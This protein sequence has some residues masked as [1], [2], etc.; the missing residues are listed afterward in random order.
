LESL[1]SQAIIAELNKTTSQQ[2][3]DSKKQ[4]YL[5]KANEIE[6]GLQ[7][8][9]GYSSSMF[10]ICII[11]ADEGMKVHV[12]SK[13]QECKRELEQL[14]SQLG[15]EKYQHIEELRLLK[16]EQKKIEARMAENKRKA[17]REKDP[18]KKAAL[19]LLIEED[20]KKLE[21]NL[22]K[23][24]AIPTSKI[25]F[26]PGKHV[27]RIMEGIRRALAE[28]GRPGGIGGGSGSSGNRRNPN[29]PS[30]PFGGGN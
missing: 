19:L 18:S 14:K 3:Y 27:E 26:D 11:W 30:D 28:K 17:E 12:E 9:T 1:D 20:G 8:R 25:N 6:S 29:D 22:R 7:M 5:R 24:K 16:L 15:M 4:D 23:Q 21:E 10:G 2:E 13:L